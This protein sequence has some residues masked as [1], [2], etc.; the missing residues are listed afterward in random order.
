MSLS[1]GR[2]IGI[3]CHTRSRR[4]ARFALAPTLG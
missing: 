1:Y 2:A 3:S 4:R